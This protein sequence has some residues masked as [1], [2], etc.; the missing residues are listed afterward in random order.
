MSRAGCPPR[1]RRFA[2]RAHDQLPPGLEE[3]VA[4]AVHVRRPLRIDMGK[5]PLF[6]D[7]EHVA[8]VVVPPVAPP[9]GMVI[10]SADR[11]PQWIADAR[12]D[13]SHGLRAFADG[14]MTDLDA[15]PLGLSTPWSSGCVEG[16]DGHQAARAADGGPGSAPAPP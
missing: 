10:R 8:R 3:G 7:G 12:A 1:G 14:L 11:L 16:R 2:H 4:P 5:F 13:E 15:V 9:T 6:D